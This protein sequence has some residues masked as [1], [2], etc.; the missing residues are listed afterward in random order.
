MSDQ[1]QVNDW[2]VLPPKHRGR[3]EDLHDMAPRAIAAGQTNRIAELEAERDAALERQLTLIRGG[4]IILA[5]RDAALVKLTELE[6]HNKR[7]RQAMRIIACERDELVEKG[8]ELASRLSL[9]EQARIAAEG[10]LSTIRNIMTTRDPG[11]GC[12]TVSFEDKIAGVRRVLDDSAPP[13]AGDDGERRCPFMVP[14]HITNKETQCDQPEGH[15]GLH[16][17]Q[18]TPEADR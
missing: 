2:C 8:I 7:I 6:F 18:F 17:A 4:E 16:Y 9:S 12:G 14:D 13:P 11:D 1:C 5:E 3:C 15:E 10:R